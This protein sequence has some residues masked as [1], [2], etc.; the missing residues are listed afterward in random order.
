MAVGSFYMF[1]VVLNLWLIKPQIPLILNNL[2]VLSLFFR[3]IQILCLCNLF[4]S[5]KLYRWYAT[6]TPNQFFCPLNLKQFAS[7]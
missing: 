5:N 1:V 4:N 2:T 3:N 7:F 6:M